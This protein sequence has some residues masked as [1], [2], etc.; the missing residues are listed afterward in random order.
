MAARVLVYTIFVCK[1]T[2]A[3]LRRVETRVIPKET[4]MKILSSAA[5]AAL[6]VSS[7]ALAT[8][9]KAKGKEPSATEK[10]VECLCKVNIMYDGKTYFLRPFDEKSG[11]GHFRVLKQNDPDVVTAGGLSL[12]AGLIEKGSFWATREKAI[13]DCLALIPNLRYTGRTND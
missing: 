13:K 4:T 1:I 12:R 10:A 11:K 7:P 3:T 8:E 2:L 6:L 9:G 5:L